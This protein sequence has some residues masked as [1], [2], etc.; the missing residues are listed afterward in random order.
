MLVSV[1][2]ANTPYGVV[3]YLDLSPL[4]PQPPQ[5]SRHPRIV[6]TRRPVVR[7]PSSTHPQEKKETNAFQQ[8]GL[9]PEI[10]PGRSGNALH[11]SDPH[12]RKRRFPRAPGKGTC[13]APP[14][15]APKRR[16]PFALPILH[17]LAAGDRNR[18]GTASRPVA[19]PHPT[20]E[21]AIQI[22]D[23]FRR[24]RGDTPGCGTAVIY[25]GVSQKAP[26]AGAAEKGGHPR[27]HARGR[28]LDLM[29]QKARKPRDRRDLRPGRGPDRMLDM[30]FIVD[31]PPHHRETSRENGQTLMFS[32]TMPSEIVRLFG[33]P[34]PRSGTGPGRGRLPRRPTTW[35]ID[36]TNVEKASKADLLK[37][38]LE[39]RTRSRT[40]SCSRGRGTAA[41]PRGA[42]PEP[43]GVRVEAI[44][45]DKSQ[46]A[47]ERALFA[48]QEGAIRVL[49]A[50]DNR[51]PG[52]RHRR[53][54]PR[55]QLRPAERAGGVRPPDRPHRAGPGA[56][57]T[58]ISFCGFEERPLARRHRA[59]DGAS[60]PDRG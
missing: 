14:R 18:P 53:P 37:A 58:A 42:D 31:I 57:G 40:P 13:S 46:G 32:A 50:T 55:G 60:Q 15:P 3:R 36:S 48:F 16:P 19:R 34:A 30:G 51:R 27:R 52:A 8:F 10:P 5:R 33:H 38:L 59:P 25:G 7:Q 20:R 9:S 44:H 12:N 39:R 41:G 11:D 2:L 56:S 54:L 47:R 45:G 29:G 43:R 23:S 1:S 4:D 28:L 6:S 35:S 17:R 26:G 22:G 49:V 21:L 24:L